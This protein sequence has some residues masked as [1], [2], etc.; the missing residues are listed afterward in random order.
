MKQYLISVYQ[1]DGPRPPAEVLDK[2]TAELDAMRAELTDARLVGVQRRAA[3]R[4]HGDGACG[5]G[6]ARS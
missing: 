4:E 2:M 5:P 6:T 3:R 1:P